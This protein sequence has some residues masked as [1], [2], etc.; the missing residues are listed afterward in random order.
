[1]NNLKLNYLE[2]AFLVVIVTITHLILNMPNTLIETTGS[3]SII[4]T[5][6]VTVLALL[7][8]SIIKK[9]LD[10]FENNN[11][12]YVAEFLGGKILKIIITVLYLAHFIFIS[13]ILLRNFAEF[14]KIIYFPQASLWTILSAF[15]LVSLIVNRLGGKNIVKANAILM[16]P[17][18]LTIV[19]TAISLIGKLEF[20]RVF[21]ILGY[22]FKETFFNGATNI[23]AFSGILYLLL[24]KPYLKNSKNFS[25]IGY[26]SIIISG[27]YLV[28]IVSALLMMFPYI[29]LGNDTLSVYLSTRIIE[30]G[31]FMQRTDAIYMFVWIF[32][33]L[34]YL[35]IIVLF[36]TQ[37]S[38]QSFNLKKTPLYSYIVA[39]IIFIVAMLPNNT[40]EL[41]F[42]ETTI[43]KYSSIGIVFVVSFIVLVLGY[44]KKKKEGNKIRYEVT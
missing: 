15:L 36:I 12:I 32:D 37:I 24:I 33:F 19:I 2:S 1:M 38:K 22:G 4:N 28:L 10:P 16:I 39:F 25:K 41:E 40:T 42:F 11:I 44:L 9:L 5:I 30:Y 6:Y 31:K 17:I 29:Q 23:Y 3:A 27:I 13:A 26:L 21:P 7:L 35:S 34:S 18:L 8:F 43:Y 20:N 14:L